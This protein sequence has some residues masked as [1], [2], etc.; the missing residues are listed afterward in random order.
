MRIRAKNNL[1]PKSR[2]I[3]SVVA[4]AIILLCVMALTIPASQLRFE[5]KIA[6][7]DDLVAVIKS[8]DIKYLSNCSIDAAGN[9]TI[10][11]EDAHIVFSGL[12]RATRTVK[13]NLNG[14]SSD[15]YFATLYYDATF[16]FSEDKTD[17]RYVTPGDESVCFE[18]PESINNEL[19]LDIDNNY[20]FKSIELHSKA[21][22][23][24]SIPLNIPVWKYFFALM[25][26][27]GLSVAFFLFDKYVYPLSEK[28]V[29]GYLRNYKKI[30]L[31]ALTVLFLLVVAVGIEFFLSRFIFG[32][33]S[34][35]SYFN[36][37][38][39]FFIVCVLLSIVFVIK[40]IKNNIQSEKIFAVLMLI[41]GMCMIICSPFGHICWDY[42]SHTK[43]V[44]EQSYIGDRYVTAADKKIFNN[45]VPF[46]G[47]DALTNI[48]NIELFDEAGNVVIGVK[49]K[50][51]T[52]IAHF[53]TGLAVAVTRFLGFSYTTSSMFGRAANLLVYILIC[54]FAMIKLKS[55][56]AILATI[57]FF[58]TNLFLATN[59]SYD[60]WVTAFIFL[61]TAYFISEIKQQQKVMSIRDIIIMNGAF[62]L[63]CIP[64]QIYMPIMVLPL[65]MRKKWKNKSQQRKYYLICL[66]MLA[67]MAVLLIVRAFSSVT[68]G[69][70]TRGGSEVNSMGQVSFIFSE[71]FGYTK[72]LLNFLKTYLSI[73]S[74]KNYIN[75]FAY[76][77]NGTVFVTWLFIA[78]IVFT[79]ATDKDKYD[80]F[81]GLNCVRVI[82]ILLFFGIICLVAT[83]LYISF[84][85]VGS[86]TIHGCQGRY[87]TPLLLPLLLVVASPGLK[88]KIN[89]IIYNNILFVVLASAVF[90]DVGCVFLPKLM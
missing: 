62:I 56:K 63:A 78:A 32:V 3:A 16:D 52:T 73:G 58:P 70:D 30:L 87:I 44:L 7:T 37:Y 90:V 41:V 45:E 20:T 4:F 12:S 40:Q 43:F 38:R 60:Y 82:D 23:T 72:I 48:K 67:F 35:G 69:G 64:K 59:Y 24:I 33:S 22:N 8:D 66:A 85:A 89:K 47:K 71:P 86:N 10:N 80:N 39:Y 81:N 65:L 5:K 15:G 29:K 68:G 18:I 1:S 26:S 19:R 61:G 77:G 42:D 17:N 54:Y 25:I 9:V 31:N 76:L 13:L 46:E 28:I 55:G 74:M 79:T 11:G 6:Q 14:K 84:T 36:G 50:G 57:A 83:S 53:H 88:L 27:I 21:P 51:F 75:T 49:E 2:I 34:T